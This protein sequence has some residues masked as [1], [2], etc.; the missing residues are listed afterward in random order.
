MSIGVGDDTEIKALRRALSDIAALSS[1][2]SIWLIADERR[3]AETLADA[4]VRV[5]DLQYVRV[6]LSA[7]VDEEVIDIERGRPDSRELLREAFPDHDLTDRPR[8]LASGGHTRA[9]RIGVGL[10]GGRIYAVA[11]RRSFPTDAEHLT[12][13]IAANQAAVALSRA[14]SERALRVQTEALDLERKAV[15][16]LNRSLSEERDRLRRSEANLRNLNATLE[17]RVAEQSRERDR[18]WRNSRDLLA[19]V[20]ADGVF[21]A[22]NPAWK[23]ILDHDPDE[24]VGRSFLEFIWPDDADLTL[25]GHKRAA[26][27]EALTSFENRYRH[28]DGSPRWISWHTTTEDGLIYAYG[29]DI[30]LEKR[31][32]EA[33][34]ETEE[35]LHH[36]QKMEAIG[37]LTGGVAHDFNN[38]LTVIRSSADL[39]RRQNL[40]EE[41]RR[42][43]V[44]AISDTADR[45]ARVTAQLLAFARRQVLRPTVFD[46]AERL[47][48]V[49][50][51]VKSILG[52]GIS[53][54]LELNA[55]PAFVEADTSQ[56]ETALVNLAAN[57]RDAMAGQGRLIIRLE[58]AEAPHGLMASSDINFSATGFGVSVTDSGCGIPA[59]KLGQIFEPFFTTKE[60]GHGTGLGLSQ[61]YGFAQQS[62]GYLSVQ[63]EVGQG[64][65]FNLFLPATM[66]VADGAAAKPPPLDKIP[67]QRGCVLVVEDN[68]EVGDFSSQLLTDLG[69]STVLVSSGEEAL[70]LLSEDPKQFD[71][72]FSDVVM[73]NMDGV[74]LGQE[75]RRRLP[76]LPFVLTSGY[77]QV[78][79]EGGVQGFQ[80]LQKPYSLESLSGIL[81]AAISGR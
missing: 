35:K 80:L 76:N 26:A 29:R 45:A 66:K 39:L 23:T 78:L 7:V 56:F 27:D 31:Q 12:L 72:V 8:D 17:I 3:I 21:R 63:S 59:D 33:L 48:G 1:L 25:A 43:Y 30:T 54:D 67:P 65:T 37:K 74:T 32:T 60:I 2:P 22:V 9:V 46:L 20:G 71:L 6:A 28:R 52:S 77:S 61:V 73:P 34:R 18:I 42:R 11:G 49:A 5:L 68:S 16:L 69:Y 4:I 47:E 62:N 10:T 24:I 55:K 15:A 70:K 14:R 13:V 19:V 79:A 58:K 36:A 75:V 51:I 81:Q 53:L 44:D 50:E 57:A 38:L 41:R 40:T 64:A